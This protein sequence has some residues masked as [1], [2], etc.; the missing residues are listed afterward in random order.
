[1]HRFLSSIAA[2]V[3]AFAT[4]VLFVWVFLLPD[5]PVVRNDPAI[6]PLIDLSGSSG[7]NQRPFHE[8]TGIESL[9]SDKEKALLLFEPTLNKWIKEEEIA[10]VI[11]PS[12]AVIEKIAATRLHRYEAPYLTHL[13]QQSYKPSLLD[14]NGDR[15]PELAIM[16]NCEKSDTC[17]LWLFRETQPDFEVILRTTWKLEAFKVRKS[18][19]KGFSDIQT[20]YYPRDPNSETFKSMNDYKFNGKEYTHRGCSAILD[21]YWDRNWELQKLEKPV[22]ERYDDCC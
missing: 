2:S 12:L 22:F 14:L 5:Y 21:H 18:K 9:I 3:L 19:S 6:E 15:R 1:M 16:I 10:D 13:A 7:S 8:E 20:S 4:G 17:E 11:E